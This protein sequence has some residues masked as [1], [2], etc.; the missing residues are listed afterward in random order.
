M[1]STN[2]T[3]LFGYRISPITLSG[4]LSGTSSFAP[5]FTSTAYSS[6]LR[7]TPLTEVGVYSFEIVSDSRWNN[8]GSYLT[9]LGTVTHPD[10]SA[11]PLIGRLNTAMGGIIFSDSAFDFGA[12]DRIS[13]A[14]DAYLNVGNYAPANS[15]DVGKKFSFTVSAVTVPIAIVPSASSVSEGGNAVFTI[16]ALASISPGTVVNYSITGINASDTSI[17]LN[18][19]TR[20]NTDGMA[21][22]T[23][24]LL[25]DVQTEGSE[26]LTLT[27]GGVAANVTVLDTS[28]PE[29]SY[30]LVPNKTQ[31]AEGENAVFTLTATNVLQGTSVPY[32]LSGISADDVLGGL[33]G[34]AFVSAYGSATIS[35]ALAPDRITEGNETLTLTA[36]NISASATILDTSRSQILTVPVKLAANN[37]YYGFLKGYS[38]FQEAQGAAAAESHRGLGGYLATVTSAA[39]DSFIYS[40]VIL[41]MKLPTTPGFSIGLGA[42]DATAE[43]T[44]RWLSGPESGQVLVYQRWLSGQPDSGTQQNHLAYALGSPFWED[45]HADDSVFPNGYAGF[46]VEFGGLPASYVIKPSSAS[47]EEGQ[48][49][50]FTIDTQNVEWGQ[51]ISYSVAS[52]G[53][54][55]QDLVSGSMSGTAQVLQMGL[56]GTASV[57][58]TLAKDFLTEGAETLTLKVGTTSSQ[59]IV[60]DT[61]LSSAANTA[62]GTPDK[63]IFVWGGT[64]S[65][66]FFDGNLGIDTLNVSGNKKNHT[67]NSSSITDKITSNKASLSG[68]ERLKFADAHV[69]LDTTAD[70]NAAKAVLILGAVLGKESVKVPAIVGLA[71]GLYDLG[72]LPAATI[73]TTALTAA[74]GESPSDTDVVNLLYKNLTGQA[75]DSVS[76]SLY[77]SLLKTGLL[78]HSSLAQMAADSDLNK[79]NINLVGLVQ[80]GVEFIPSLL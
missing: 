54:T 48:T 23:I 80:E 59:V 18:G 32:T 53:I 66:K 10:G 76:L 34:T 43:G 6:D 9:A 5:F 4:T 14:F 27:V 15:V 45:M 17:S 29:P 78:T 70:G 60:K 49:V 26:L 16:T 73:A 71:I 30:T 62:N 35:V 2:T 68:I 33:N 72:T 63:D 25:E 61:S 39:E 1:S 19:S 50:T 13:H 64:S 79:A 75:P 57:S 12:N 8:D 31:F 42:S 47:V 44:W 56:N 65:I 74:L 7:P 37:H 40:D 24:P 21:F 69:A 46:V 67:F 20:I 51:S 77:S 28:R 36:Q 52:N 41:P 58:F 38:S 22:V 55:S 11:R 3:G